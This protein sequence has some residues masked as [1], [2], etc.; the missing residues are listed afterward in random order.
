MP[1]GLRLAIGTLTRVPVPIPRRVDRAA[2]RGAMLW[3]PVVGGLLGLLL[4][5]AGGALSRWAGPATSALLVSALV[6][7]ASAYVTRG[8][9]LD[10]LADL[11]DA[12]GSGRPSTDALEIARRSDI[13]PF[14]VVT[15][16][17]ALIVQVTA[18]AGLV[19]AGEAVIGLVVAM[20]TGRL[21]L[22]IA[23]S[24]AVPAARPDGLGA[25]VAG[26]IP[27]LVAVA[28]PLA[29]V[30]VTVAAT[31]ALD[32]SGHSRLP[33]LGVGLA[34]GLGLAAGIGVVRVA[35]RRLGGITGDVLGA[36]VEV[37]TAA[38]LVILVIAAT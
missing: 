30:A 38:T 8:I 15:V 20:L 2:A 9:H 27:G 32:A 34:M 6:V 19:G 28:A 1:D 16:T 5:L 17:L 22:V 18:Y 21:A 12:L 4:G 26:S 13:G 31:A 11:A 14:G 37:V 3:A 29:W 36:V 25:T 35:V 23:C 10:G 24:R 33:A 7:G